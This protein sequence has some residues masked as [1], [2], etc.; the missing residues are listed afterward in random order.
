MT[1]NSKVVCYQCHKSLEIEHEQRILR[2]EEC[3]HCQVS[4]YCCRMC[5]FYDK[6]SYNECR[7][8]LAERIV[9]KEKANFCSYFKIRG[10]DS[11]STPD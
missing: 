5:V 8:P 2:H 6:N 7:E 3:S 11:S 9:D 4:L 1:Q 10:G